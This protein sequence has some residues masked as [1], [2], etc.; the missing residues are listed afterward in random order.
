MKYDSPQRA[1][2]ILYFNLSALSAWSDEVVLFSDAVQSCFQGSHNRVMSREIS[3][4]FS[5][6][7]FLDH[8]PDRFFQSKGKAQARLSKD[9]HAVVHVLDTVDLLIVLPVMKS[10]PNIVN[11][12]AATQD[13]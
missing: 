4:A 9:S 13:A 7:M 10:A 6:N 11:V 8:L 12:K 3:R 1:F 5:E 2:S